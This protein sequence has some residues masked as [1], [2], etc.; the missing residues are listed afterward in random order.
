[1]NED[2]EAPPHID[3]NTFILSLSTS[4]LMHLGDLPGAEE[5]STLGLA[6]A[7]QSIDCIAL[8]EA[9]TRGNL[10]GEEERLITEVL[11]DLRL[12]FVKAKKAAD[13]KA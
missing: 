10:T 5:D 12:R 11:Y 2:D 4:A 1:M 8:L 3:F 7:K 9:K 6:H 13:S